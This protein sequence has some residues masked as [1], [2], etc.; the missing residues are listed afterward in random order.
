[1]TVATQ[2]TRFE[3]LFV[4]QTKITAAASLAAPP[5]ALAAVRADLM[6]QAQA[7]CALGS[8]FVCDVLEAAARQLPRAP[9]LALRLAGWPVD[10]AAAALALRVNGALHAL[11]R[12]GRV[13]SLSAVYAARGGDIDQAVADAFDAADDWLVQA[14][15]HPT[16]TNE[17]ARSAA[18][19]AGLMIAATRFDQ[20]V[21]LLELGS[22]A[23]LNLNLA[24]YAYCLG[25]TAAGDP[26]STVRIAPR[27][28]GPS[29]VRHPL[30]IASA[31]GVDLF[32]L[33]V[34]NPSAC[35][36][37]LSW[38]WADRDDRM[39]QLQAAIR[40]ARQHPPRID[41]GEAANWLETALAR[42]QAAGVTRAVIHSM[43]RQYC[44]EATRARI[45]RA[46][47]RAA[48][49]A[50]R[51]RPLAYLTYEWDESR[52]KVELLLTTWPDGQT[53]LIAQPDPYGDRVHWIGG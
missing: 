18:L 17:V 21:E 39:A 15:A 12:S 46:L 28:S 9:Q 47:A 33:D 14:I 43:L 1:M 31:T 35:E 32:P 19:Y 36:R 30:A 34:S 16:Q 29:P 3:P 44:D 11:A 10:R 13:S 20:P 48:A 41:R 27:W 51:T 24:R 5:A 4:F 38:V 53:R 37:L 49:A 52:H 26:A 7:A 2:Q 8:P 45:A 23:G 50:D 6:R 22:S 42:P 40:I 25:G